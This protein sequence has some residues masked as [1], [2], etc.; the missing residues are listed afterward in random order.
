MSGAAQQVA[1]TAELEGVQRR[2]D[3]GTEGDD[4]RVGAAAEDPGRPGRLA[5]ALHP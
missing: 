1:G 3:Q 4:G 2:G 5:G